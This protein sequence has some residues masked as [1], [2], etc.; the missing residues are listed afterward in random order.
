M[1]KVYDAQG[2]AVGVKL[3]VEDYDALIEARDELEDTE[4]FYAARESRDERIPFRRRTE[5]QEFHAKGGDM[6]RADGSPV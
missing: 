6:V 5:R 1:E 4:R 2:I 3:P